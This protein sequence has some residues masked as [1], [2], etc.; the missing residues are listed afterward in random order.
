MT[1]YLIEIKEYAIDDLYE[2]Y[3][4]ISKDSLYYANLTIRK[5]EQTIN[6]LSYFPYIGRKIP[7]LNKEDFLEI[8]YKNYR[9]MY[10]VESDN[11]ILVLRILHSARK[12]QI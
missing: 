2:I 9:I 11:K 4:Y 12:F 8:I 1:K 10:K 5:I 3:H 6:R 7:E